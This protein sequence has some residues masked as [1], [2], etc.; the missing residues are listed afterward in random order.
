MN[1][2]TRPIADNFI[3]WNIVPEG[4]LLSF[5]DYQVGPHSF[6]R[7]ELVVPFSALRN[8]VRQDTV[9]KLLA[10]NKPAK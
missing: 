4:V 1:E 8:T 9:K 3:S 7:P 6:G 2:G 5:D 10:S